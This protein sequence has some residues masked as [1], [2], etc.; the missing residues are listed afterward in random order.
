MLERMNAA[1]VHR[2]PDDAGYYL[3]PTSEG[4]VQ[5]G[6][7]MRR[8]SI[9]DLETGQQPIANEDQTCWIV[10]NGEIYNHQRL[11]QE[12]EGHGHVFRTRSDTEAILHAYEQYGVDCVRRLRGMFAFAIWDSQQQRLFLA[13][14]PVGIKP[15]YWT[16]AGNRLLFASEA[17]ALFQDDLVRREV[18]REGL[19]HFLTYLYVPPPQTMFAG[20]QRLAPGHR[21][22]WQGG[23][24]TI[25]EYWRGPEALLDG[26]AGPPVQPE[27]V[28]ETLRE[29]VGAHMLADVP[30]GSFLSGGLDSSAITALMAELSPQPVRTFSIGFRAS[31]LYD[32]LKYAREV[33]RRLRTDHNEL[34]V[35]PSAVDLLPEIIRDLDEPLA[36]AS[37]IPN[38]LVARLARPFVKVA[39]TGTGGDELFGGYRRYYGDRM[40]RRWQRIPGPLRRNV[41]LPALRIVPASG[42]TALGEAS[43]LAQKFLEPLDL[44][45]EQRYMAWNAFFSEEAKRQ[46]YAGGDCRPE[47]NSYSVLLGHF[48]RVRH[49]PFADRAM[50]VDLKS[51]LPGDPL[52][53]SDRMTMA[54]S[55]EARVPF[56]DPKV[57]ELAARVPLSQK[58]QGRTTKL[59]LRQVL[60]GRVPESVIRRPKRGFGTPIDL[61]LRRELAGLVDRVLSPETLRERGYFRPEYVA[62]LREQHASGKRDFSQH[63]WAL[64][65]FE[66]WQRI[67]IDADL[68]DRPGLTF[69]DL[70]LGPV[71]ERRPAH[72]AATISGQR[73]VEARQDRRTRGPGQAILR[74]RASPRPPSGGLRLLLGADV[75][76]VRPCSGAERVL[77]EHARRLAERGHR[78]VVLT[79][80]EDP[81]SPSDEEYGGVRVVRHAAGGMGPLGFVSSVVNHGGMAFARLM[82]QESFDLLAVY[83]PLAATA[84]FSRPE[85]RGIPALYNYLS[86]WSDEYRFRRIQ[87]SHPSTGLTAAADRAWVAL[88]SQARKRMEHRAV[89]RA[90]RMLVLS[91]FSTSQ[92]RDI[93][94]IPVEKVSVIPGGVDTG[95]FR[96]RADRIALRR[97]LGLPS[98]PLLLTIRGLEPRMGLDTLITAMQQV[99]ALRR[100]CHLFIGGVGPLRETLQQQVCELGLERN[101]RFTGFIPEDRLADYYAATDLFVLPTRY[102]EGFGLVTIEALACGTP[103]LGTPVGGT[104]EIL[105]DFDP[106]FLFRSTEA[107]EIG[108]RILEQLPEIEGNEPLRARCRRYALEN[109]SWDVVIPRVEALMTRM[110]EIGGA[111]AP[112]AGRVATSACTAV[113]D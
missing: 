14:D 16:Q 33:A 81:A 1:L 73:V 23:T 26:V 46:L 15:L 5:V 98:G 39:L 97:D 34:V 61:W 99:V 30:L 27:T 50:Y 45:A 112:V 28:W 111:G 95:R 13:R 31:G 113:R 69:A 54:N 19:H 105:R 25:E 35:D 4:R 64:L 108:A 65:V 92:L 72:R 79:R 40:A 100:D 87:R 43:R 80:Q 60:A 101:V 77:N 37:V 63:I 7:A 83:Q 41:L 17:K 67:F 76:P 104:Q 106:R 107:E 48:Q 52:F 91:D 18:N 44:D 11:R 102:L 21:M 86:P 103:V 29:S 56:L 71:S 10:F 109:Y 93:H 3:T 88:N 51:Y 68:S 75:D 9:I 90:D 70:G 38:Y 82:E 55:L 2:G 20:V 84:V 32:E 78:V 85:S 42:D 110:V 74:P 36:D 94:A 12:L 6:L 8:L 62:W 47:L 22:L 24:V 96:P 49:R 57:M 53:L 89:L 58:I 59:I 66:L